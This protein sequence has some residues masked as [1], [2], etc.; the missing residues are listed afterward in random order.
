MPATKSRKKTARGQRGRRKDPKP[1]H[2]DG[3]APWAK[4]KNRDERLHYTYVYAGDGV[5]HGPDYY[6]SIGY[7]PVEYSADG[8]A[9]VAG[10]TGNPG[11]QI[12]MRGHVLMACTLERKAEI[13]QYGPDGVSGQELAD[14]IEEVMI[15]NRG[16]LDH[17][18]GLHGPRGLGVEV[19]TREAE[20]EI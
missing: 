10:V 16:G 19:G 9:P 8:V 20:V 5:D 4:L 13:D 18:R 17:L 6:R 7:E 14:E 15:D 11:D 2:T 1:R 12:E 3:A